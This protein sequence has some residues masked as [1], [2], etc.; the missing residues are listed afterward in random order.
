M[1]RRQKP[2]GSG[3]GMVRGVK[4][5]SCLLLLPELYNTKVRTLKCLKNTHP[6]CF[7]EKNFQEELM[8]PNFSNG[9]IPSEYRNDPSMF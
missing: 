3:E 5:A 7:K 2:W 4:S 1:S 8:T 9:P 6:C